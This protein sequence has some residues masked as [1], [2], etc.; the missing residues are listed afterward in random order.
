MIRFY[1]SRSMPRIE[2]TPKTQQD[3]VFKHMTTTSDF[4]QP[5]LTGMVRLRLLQ[6]YFETVSVPVKSIVP[7]SYTLL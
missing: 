2:Q 1:A 5:L 4:F 7:W 6:L 3:E